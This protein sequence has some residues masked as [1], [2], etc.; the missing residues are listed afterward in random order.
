MGTCC[1]DVRPVGAVIEHLPDLLGFAG[2]TLPADELR[3]R[4]LA[5]I[6]V[7]DDVPPAAQLTARSLA[8][9][10]GVTAAL[11]AASDRAL[12]QRWA[13]AFRRDGWWALYGGLQHDPSGRLRGFAVFDHAG[14]HSPTLGG[15]WTFEISRPLDD[16]RLLAELAAFGVDVREPGD[17]PFVT[18]PD[19]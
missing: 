17:L 13:A 15:E 11:W 10:F 16:E 12:T 6:E 9:R 5:T 19:P 8:G 14:A 3:S 1:F 2:F 18:P 4:R 7:P